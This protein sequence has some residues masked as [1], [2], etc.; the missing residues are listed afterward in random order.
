VPGDQGGRIGGEED[1]R[2]GDILRLSDPSQRD[3]PLGR[4]VDLLDLEHVDKTEVM[5]DARCSSAQVCS[6]VSTLNAASLPTLPF[7]PGIV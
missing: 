4:G 1:R 2:P 5:N 6:S 3:S 7:V